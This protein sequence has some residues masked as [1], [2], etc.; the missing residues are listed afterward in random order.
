MKNNKNSNI[1][2][3][4]IILSCIWVFTFIC[5]QILLKKYSIN[6]ELNGKLTIG[7]ILYALIGIIFTTPAPFISAFLVMHYIEKNSLKQ[8][9][10]NMFSKKNMLKNIFI[11]TAFCL[12]PFIYSLIN[13]IYSGSKWYMTPISFIVMIPFVGLA[14][15]VGW[16]GFLQPRL[17]KRFK[18][19]ISV[20]ITSSIWYVW[21]F[22]LWLD[23][24]SNHYGDSL[25]GFGITIFIWAFAL[26]SLY[27]ATHSVFAC[28]IYHSFIDSIGT[29]YDWNLLFD[30]FPG[31]I[32]LNVFRIIWLISSIVIWLY[33][34]KKEKTK[35]IG[36]NY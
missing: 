30:S 24:T 17:E 20:L 19:P 5:L 26:A 1:K 3:F 25:I 15:E 6:Y 10:E 35:I 22:D 2:L 4:L 34:D 12:L 9:F 32:K 28:A 18:Y 8:I 33:I 11:T 16:R 14:E 31:N 29:I 21:H 7:Y 27:K 23:Q 13:G 36:N